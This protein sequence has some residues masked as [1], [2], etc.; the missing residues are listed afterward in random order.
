MPKVNPFELRDLGMKL[1]NND[2]NDTTWNTNVSMH[3]PNWTCYF[4]N[5]NK[6][7]LGHNKVTFFVTSFQ[8]VG[9]VKV[10]SFLEI[11]HSNP[12]K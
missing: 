12:L 1:H 10:T 4:V 9:F 2:N 5:L 3:C 11:E 7:T 8:K 6:S